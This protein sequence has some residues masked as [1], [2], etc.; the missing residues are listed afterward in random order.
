MFIPMRLIV[1]KSSGQSRGERAQILSKAFTLME[2]IVVAAIMGL[3]V[4]IILT[5][6]LNILDVWRQSIRLGM[7]NQQARLTLDLLA[8]DL[9]SSVMRSDGSEWL[10]VVREEIS[11]NEN[12]FTNPAWLMF[13]S[14]L[15][16]RDRESQGG[17]PI[18]GDICAV[19][20]RLAYPNSI[21]TASSDSRTLG[22]Y[23]TVMDAET[24]FREAL[25]ITAITGSYY[26][27]FWVPRSSQATK[28]ENLLISNLFDFRLHFTFR[29]AMG[30]LQLWDAEKDFIYGGPE[31]N[32]KGYLVYVDIEMKVLN[33]NRTENNAGTIEREQLVLSETQRYHRRVII[34]SYP[35]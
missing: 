21:N 11:E 16:D 29:D 5:L 6:S 23:R 3:L 20:Y 12:R 17:A 1:N 14:Q 35:L 8:R 32:V 33:P 7:I 2:I 26:R 13:F 34:P 9:E 18:Y 19:S 10:R 4:T 22:L 30:S 31:S 27:N 15:P 28:E 24:T 25:A